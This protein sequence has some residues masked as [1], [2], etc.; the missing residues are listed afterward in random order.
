MRKYDTGKPLEN[1]NRNF[2]QLVT[3]KIAFF[4]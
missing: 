3:F 2:N 4:I 1:L